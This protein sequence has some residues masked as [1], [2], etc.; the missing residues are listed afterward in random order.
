VRPSPVT[1]NEWRCEAC[2]PVLPLQVESYLSAA[3]LAGIRAR[4]RAASDADATMPLWCPW[5]LLTGWTVTGVAWVGDDG[6]GVRAT[7]V[8]LSGPAPVSDGPADAV[9]VAEEMGVGL[10]ARF[11]GI[12]GTDP[13]PSLQ[14]LVGS[15]NANAKVRVAGHPTPLWAVESL[16]DRSVYVGEARAMWLYVI[17]WPAS[18]GYVLAEQITLHDLVESQP[19]ELVFGAPSQRL[20][21]LASEG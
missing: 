19:S 14:R 6:P 8:A 3:S 15:T 11:A 13:G 5:P 21:P 2:G 16:A 12:A 10:G 4:I 1:R 7:A 9:I 18:A 17:T 20:H